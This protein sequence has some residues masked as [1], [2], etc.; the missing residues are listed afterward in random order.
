MHLLSACA[1][2]IPGLRTSQTVGQAWVRQGHVEEAPAAGIGGDL[3]SLPRLAGWAG[4]HL[5]LWMDFLSTG[6]GPSTA[7]QSPP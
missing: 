3:Y 7:F 4:K 5:P 2:T 6:A 1:G